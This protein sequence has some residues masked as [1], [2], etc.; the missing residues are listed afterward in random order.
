VS[1]PATILWL[2][3]RQLFAR[4]RVWIAAAIAVIPFL[5]TFV[6][7]F[8]S[9]DREGDRFAF[10]LV[11]YKEVLLGVLLPIT[12]AIFGTTAFGGEVE[13]GTLIYALTKPVPRWLVVLLKYLVALAVTLLV[14][15]V[16]VLLS[17][18]SLRNAEL[19]G[20]FAGTF[21]L[22]CVVSGVIYCALFTLLGLV[23]K[24]GL[25]FGLLYIIFFENVMSRNFAGVKFLSA[26]ELSVAVA[27]WASG[28]LVKWPAP[29]VPM[30]TVWTVG[31][32]ILVVAIALTMRKL[33]RYELAERL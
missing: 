18:F 7:R 3:W 14:G 8:T 33:A 11:M 6:Y 2:T 9:E 25:I 30:T 16:A 27:Q 21:L 5:L 19:P 4:R 15:A 24:R 13:D 22:A 1:A 10:L 29:P 26:R 28:G 32:I 17:W 31:S 12:A 20:R 23:T